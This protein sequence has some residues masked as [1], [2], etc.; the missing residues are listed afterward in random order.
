MEQ[1]AA[2]GPDA[3]SGLPHPHISCTV[4]DRRKL[5]LEH[6]CRRSVLGPVTHQKT[7]SSP[8]RFLV[9]T[10]GSD[11]VAP[12]APADIAAPGDLDT[13]SVM[14]GPPDRCVLN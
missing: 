13:I 3:L 1:A 5:T 14:P 11:Q 2:G 7:R 10:I 12:S 4:C 6:A 9:S 8:P